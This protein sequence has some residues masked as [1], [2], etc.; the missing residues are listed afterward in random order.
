[1]GSHLLVTTVQTHSIVNNFACK[2]WLGKSQVVK[3]SV[4]RLFIGHV[5]DSQ[6]DGN[7]LLFLGGSLRV[8]LSFDKDFIPCI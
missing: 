1:V 6:R 2:V 7:Q 5:A 3:V 4:K 8:E